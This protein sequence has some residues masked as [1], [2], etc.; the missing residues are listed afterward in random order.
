MKA[1]QALNGNKNATEN[2]YAA[3][4]SKRALMDDAEQTMKKA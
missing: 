1:E 2:D 3:L 4:A